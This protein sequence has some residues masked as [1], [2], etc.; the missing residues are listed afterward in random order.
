MS[1]PSPPPRAGPRL[2]ASVTHS[3]VA[4]R[5]AARR[6]HETE[7]SRSSSKPS[8]RS[9]SAVPV[10]AESSSTD[11]DGAMED[12]GY[13]SQGLV[14]QPRTA[15]SP[16]VQLLNHELWE[17]FDRLDNEM[18]ITRSGRCLFPVVNVRLHHLR[19]DHFYSLGVDIL[20]REPVERLRY[21]PG[22]GW[23]VLDGEKDAPAA[24]ACGG[25]VLHPR[26]PMLGSEWMALD[27]VEFKTLKLS[28]HFPENAESEDQQLADV[29]DGV[30]RITSFY[31]YLPRFHLIDH[32]RIKSPTA[33]DPAAADE[34]T[35]TCFEFDTTK[36][37]AV[38]HYQNARN[39]NPHAK[40]F[41]D[42][43]V[44]TESKTLIQATAS[45][46]TKKPSATANSAANPS[47]VY[48][49][50]QPARK[51]TPRLA[52]TVRLRVPK[53]RAHASRST[54]TTRT[55]YESKPRAAKR[56]KLRRSPSLTPSAASS[57]SDE[58]EESSERSEL[59]E[60]P[61]ESAGAKVAAEASKAESTSGDSSSSD[62]SDTE[63][64]KPSAGGTPIFMSRPRDRLS[65]ILETPDRAARHAGVPSRPFPLPEATDEE[66]TASTAS[67]SSVTAKLE[68]PD[69]QA[70][71]PLEE[72]VHSRPM[73]SASDI[74]ALIPSLKP[75]AR[76]Q[77]FDH[78]GH[79]S[80]PAEHHPHAPW[81]ET[82][83]TRHH[84]L[85]PAP[86]TQV[87]SP[88]TPSSAAVA[89]VR[90][91]PKSEGHAYVSVFAD[92]PH[93]LPPFSALF[94]DHSSSPRAAP[95]WPSPCPSFGN[96]S[97][98]DRGK[99]MHPWVP[100]ATGSAQPMVDIPPQRAQ[101]LPGA[102]AGAT[103]WTTEATASSSPLDVLAAAA[104]FTHGGD[105]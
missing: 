50:H 100:L 84:S 45:K 5:D 85:A 101:E 7:D 29:R 2:R 16:T 54:A 99:G 93:R 44:R 68:D 96:E 70:P 79:R 38:T 23:S 39:C 31:R 14:E 18:I 55:A 25:V 104:F 89:N 77:T 86:G 27:E 71:I 52:L 47:R 103:R 76:V 97:L 49:L 62:S 91:T 34:E 48:H 69:E 21:K 81:S 13:D 82:K 41:K 73:F 1:D 28:N 78:Q 94:G 37:I 22:A 66:G 80:A 32:G 46:V 19:R 90:A 24:G 105:Q 63:S 33:A 51:P 83:P 15:K 4:T 36:F 102:G 9:R 59:E 65:C 67:E 17:A 72:A 43:A 35:T 88:H 74:A 64:S 95:A 92:E 3:S 20:R 87:P 42:E 60:D 10:Q 26:S 30:F 40:G 98:K 8:R 57:S 61:P 6:K 11:D 58:A 75:V 12:A 53:K 56:R